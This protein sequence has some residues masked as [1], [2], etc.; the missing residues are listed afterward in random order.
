LRLDYEVKLFLLVSIALHDTAVA[1]WDAKY[2]YDYLRPIT[3]IRSLGD[4]RIAAWQPP[5]LPTAFAYSAP[6]TRDA[7]PFVPG[8][9][10]QV[11]ESAA[12]DW[13]PYLPTPAFPAYVSGH[14]AFTAAWARVVELVTGRPDFG[15]RAAVRRL[16]VEQRF[17][18]RPVVIDLPTLWSA[19]ESSG[20]SRI[21]GGIHWPADNR[22]G[23]AIGKTVAE[24]AWQRGQQLFLGTASPFAA[25][26][27]N[28]T[29]AYWHLQTLPKGIS[30]AVGGQLQ[31]ELA[32]GEDVVWQSITL[33]A[34]PAGSYQL[35]LAG[36]FAGTPSAI[37]RASVRA[38]GDP[39]K[40]LGSSELQLASGGPQSLNI[41][42]R[43]DGS[44]P[45]RIELRITAIAGAG[46]STFK[47][48]KFSRQWPVVQAHRVTGR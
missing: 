42:W 34:P 30:S 45:C 12:K 15:F 13:Q 22:E 8:Q 46:R 28:L 1:V 6:A 27:S 35:S 29:P 47:A 20:V 24:R 16:Y 17:L 18:D 36:E 9:A 32:P 38:A 41:D 7:R 43:S 21:Y 37:V 48:M 33:D 26:V 31:V 40:V 5:Q 4:V 10:K 3:V 25:A 11:A 2:Y 44:T 23:L 14:S 39:D 19:A